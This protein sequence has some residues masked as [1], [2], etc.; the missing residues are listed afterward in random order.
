MDLEAAGI[1]GLH[2]LHPTLSRKQVE[3][4]LLPPNSQAGDDSDAGDNDT[5]AHGYET[6]SGDNRCFTKQTVSSTV[7]ISAYSLSE[8]SGILNRHCTS[9][10]VSRIESESRP[11][12][13]R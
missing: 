6:S 5:L 9:T 3:P 8:M 7:R 1:E 11:R 13:S 2:P 4:E 12:S 10:I